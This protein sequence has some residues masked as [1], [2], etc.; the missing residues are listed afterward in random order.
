MLVSGLAV[1]AILTTLGGQAWH[2]AWLAMG[3]ASAVAVWPSAAAVRRLPPAAPPRV[4]GAAVP[5]TSRRA[6]LTGVWAA[7]LSYALFAVGYLA[8]LTFL[9]AWMRD[10]GLSVAVSA[11][12]WAGL[13]VLVIASP[14]V[15]R[16]VLARARAGG[17]MAAANLATALAVALPLLRPDAAGTVVSAMAFGLSFFVVPTAATSFCRRYFEE[18]QWPSTMAV[19]TLVFASGQIVGPVAAGWI[20]DR[21]GDVG[22]GLAAAALVLLAGAL[23]ALLQR[24]RPV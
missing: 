15:W 2:W 24:P 14:F 6:R 12:A 13:S 18:P 23:I 4:E 11:L 17:A 22:G 20:A 5:P 16:P 7:L 3:I 8:Y 9:V 21:T 19:F 10:L 1:P